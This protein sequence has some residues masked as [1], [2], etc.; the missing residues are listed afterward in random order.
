MSTIWEKP[1]TVQVPL[2]PCHGASKGL[3]IAQGPI[4]EKHPLILREDP[5]H[6]VGLLPSI[7][8]DDDYE[9]SGN[10]ATKAIGETGLFGLA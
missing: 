7:I 9:D 4:P 6:A 3:M 8:K 2:P 1:T 5:R 10:H